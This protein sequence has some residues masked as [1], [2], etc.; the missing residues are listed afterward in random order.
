MSYSYYKNK[1]I[2]KKE[3]T[4]QMLW[5]QD[6]LLK[7]KDFVSHSQQLK[8]S[9]TVYYGFSYLNIGHRVTDVVRDVVTPIEGACCSLKL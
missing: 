6:S 9:T 2:S 4:P 7:K 3:D 5:N 1:N 8:V